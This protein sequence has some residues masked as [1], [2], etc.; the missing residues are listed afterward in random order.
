MATRKE[1][2]DLLK[3]M[4][5][6]HWVKRGFSCFLELGVNKRGHLRGDVVCL[7][8]GGKIIITEVKSCRADFTSDKKWEQYLPFC[9]QFYFCWP[10]DLGVELPPGVGVLVPDGRGWLKA[11]KPAANQKVE[12]ATRRMLI[13]RMAWRAGTYSKR[14]TRRTRVYL[15]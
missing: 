15:G 2:A 11:L 4:V 8:L 5:Y 6:M 9:D 7:N 12:G 14:N 1:T 13:T 3:K 10:H